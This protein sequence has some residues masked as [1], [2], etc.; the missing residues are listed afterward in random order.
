MFEEDLSKLKNELIRRGYSSRTIQS[1]TSCVKE[2][3]RFVGLRYKKLDEVTIK[4]FLFGLS[5]KG[6]APLTVNLYLSAIRFFYNEILNYNC[7]I[8]IK[9]SKKAKKL[10]VVLSRDEV[11]RLIAVTKNRKHKNLLALAYGAGLRISEVANLRVGDI[12]FQEKTIHIKNAKGK[13][14]RITL[15]P[16]KLSMLLLKE[17]VLKGVND[18]LFPSIRGGKLNFRTIGKIFH[19]SLYLADI[20][21]PAT[22]HSLRHSFATHL[23]ENGTDMRYVQKLLGHS[24]IR[25]TQ[26]YTQVTNPA[27]KK[28][29]SP[30][31]F[32]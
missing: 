32:L 1:Y 2:Y 24:N 15:L 29:K 22:F 12:D 7:R 30:L 3:F 31:I 21:K 28:I 19:H 18:Y 27:L 11:R 10:P 14:D 4:R 13:K 16:E 8:T 26:L 23:M 6:L 25:T 20:K 9:G 5:E 17:V